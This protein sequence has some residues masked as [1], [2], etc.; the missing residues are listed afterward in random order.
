MNHPTYDQL[1]DFYYNFLETEKIEK[2][3]KMKILNSFRRF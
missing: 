2:L 3:K 1:L